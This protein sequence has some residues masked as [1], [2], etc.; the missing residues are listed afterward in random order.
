MSGALKRIALALAPLIGQD[1][2]HGALPILFAATSPDVVAEGYYG[3]HKFSEQKG[4]P[5]PAKIS[6]CALDVVIAQRL[7]E[8][9]EQLTG[10]TFNLN[11]TQRAA[12]YTALAK[13]QHYPP[14]AALAPYLYRLTVGC[15]QPIFT[16]PAQN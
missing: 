16:T 12:P 5:V 13:T 2:A 10:I 1:A 9:T 6:P 4:Y 3:P 11:S 7:W 8:K 14:L 15:A